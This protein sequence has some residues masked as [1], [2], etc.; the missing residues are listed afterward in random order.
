LHAKMQAIFCF[1][2]WLFHFS[3]YIFGSS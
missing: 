2:L 3:K 1:Y